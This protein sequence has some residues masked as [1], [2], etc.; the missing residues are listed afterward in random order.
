MGAKSLVLHLLILAKATTARLAGYNDNNHTG[1]SLTDVVITIV[2]V[3]GG[4]AGDS[5]ANSC[6]GIGMGWNKFACHEYSPD[7]IGSCV[8]VIH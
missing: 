2:I 5:V 1:L 7:L 4:Y 6:C 3:R 8:L